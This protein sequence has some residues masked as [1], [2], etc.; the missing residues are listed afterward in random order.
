[1]SIASASRKTFESTTAQESAHNRLRMIHGHY[2]QAYRDG[3]EPKAAAS[4]HGLCGDSRPR[5]SVE[6]SS[7]GRIMEGFHSPG[8]PPWMCPHA[9]QNHHRALPH[10]KRRA[11]DGFDGHE[12]T[13]MGGF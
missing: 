9:R 1:M 12:G 4:G 10:Q 13:S 2:K 11:D 3:F 5:L 8:I 7:T 6:R